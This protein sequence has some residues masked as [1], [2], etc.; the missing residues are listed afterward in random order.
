MAR[1]TAG[2]VASTV[3]VSDLD[4]VGLMCALHKRLLAG[5]TMADALHAARASI[6]RDQPLSFVTWCAFNAFG[7][8]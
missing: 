2:L 1:G 3:L 7:A 6:D 8:A 5:D 4:A